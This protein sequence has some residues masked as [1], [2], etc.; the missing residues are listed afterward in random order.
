MTLGY[1]TAADFRK[2]QNKNCLLE[3]SG[4]IQAGDFEKF[5]EAAK[6]HLPGSDG[7][8]TSRDTVC[9]NSNGGSLPEGLKF[10][11][12]FFDK[13]V[14]TVID[15][16]HVCLS[17]CALIFMMGATQG[18][19]VAYLNRKMHINGT[20][21][22]HRPAIGLNASANYSS[23]QVTKAFNLALDSA[24]E[25]LIL[26]NNIEPFTNKT[27][28]AADLLQKTFS[29]IGNDFYY[30][31]DVNKVGRW[32]I[33]I[34]GLNYP[35]KLTKRHAYRICENLSRW[36][37]GLVKDTYTLEEHLENNQ[38]MIKVVSQGQSKITYRI[39]GSSEGL[40]GHMCYIQFEGTEILACGEDESTS[41]KIGGGVCRDNDWREKIFFV[42]TKHVIFH[43]NTKLKDLAAGTQ[44]TQIPPAN[45]N[46]SD[47]NRNTDQAQC[48]VIR[49][50]RIIDN[51]P[52]TVIWGDG[53]EFITHFV[54]PSGGK[55]VVAGRGYRG[56]KVRINGVD[57]YGESREGYEICYY[58]RNTGNDFCY[59]RQ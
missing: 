51:D 36:P 53:P 12:Y 28:I 35:T 5:L 57:T 25:F 47:N 22:F 27:V 9:L 3:L 33:Q 14:T 59:K 50:G 23:K 43:P 17:V 7:E 13:G 10:A 8:S 19:E 38:D 20:L 31:D 44:A 41:T 37:V 55:T 52:C 30:I 24:I 16:S 26:A 15:D 18:D 2:V 48:Y 1:S 11:R 54:W 46:N 34:F 58:N 45:D 42:A 21:G 49:S 56:T 29:H 4:V 32:G 6:K 39:L 40:V